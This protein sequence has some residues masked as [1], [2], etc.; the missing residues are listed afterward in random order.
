MAEATSRNENRDDVLHVPNLFE[1]FCMRTAEDMRQRGGT[2]GDPPAT[3]FAGLIVTALMVFAFYIFGKPQ[4]AK[5]A[6]LLFGLLL[7]WTLWNVIIRS[8]E[9]ISQKADNIKAGVFPPAAAPFVLA[10]LKW[11]NHLVTP[12]RWGK[13][14]RLFD[15]RAKLER[16]I[17]D[18][19]R[20][21]AE[22]L[23]NSGANA[24]TYSPPKDTEIV[25]LANRINS[26]TERSAVEM[27]IG[28]K[29]DE[30]ERLRDELLLHQALLY[31][32]NEMSEKLD[33]IEKLTV[34]FQ[35]VSPD[36]LSQVV[37]EAIQILEDRRILVLSVDKI[38]PD[39]FIDLVTV[40]TS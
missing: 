20:R 34:V 33:R 8:S 35:N 12:R 36:D 22:L 37:S 32:L 38:D 21:I 23:T 30:L 25:A 4:L 17:E 15:R 40:R 2:A 1:Y 9:Q 6:F 5:A 26:F 29:D 3:S 24:S 14:S 27:E 10:R 7:L 28:T 31:K 39:D 13:H 18:I 16:R 19:Q 11:W